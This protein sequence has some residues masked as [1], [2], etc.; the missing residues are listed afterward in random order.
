MKLSYWLGH[1]FFKTVANGFFNYKVVGREVL[2]IK[3]GALFVCN[4]VSFLDPPMVGIA[5]DKEIHF[6]AR[7]TLHDHFFA[8]MV[9]RSWN[10]IPVD[11]DRPDMAALKTVIRL[12]KEGHKVLIFPEGNRAFDGALQ[13][14]EPG[15]GLI[16][17]KAQVPV[18]PM[19]LFGTYEALPRGGR[20]LHPAEITLQTGGVW[21]Y[22]PSN[23]T[24]TGKE[25][26]QKISDE[27]MG[28]IEKIKR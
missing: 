24:E 14:G 19:R 20:C 17:S 22:E 25:L 12:L 5:M 13:K 16:V 28:E 15:V 4:H 21:R 3:G 11:Q 2:D 23:Y 27:L 26:Y 7:K 10:T 18:I 8:N 9:F 1:R 6:L